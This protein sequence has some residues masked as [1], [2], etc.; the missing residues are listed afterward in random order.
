MFDNHERPH[1]ALGL[2][3]PARPGGTGRA[4]APSPERLEPFDYGPG[5][6]AVVRKVQDKGVIGFENRCWRVKALV[7]PA[8][9]VRPTSSDGVHEVFF[10]H[11][12][13]ATIDRNHAP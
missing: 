7:G 1:Q 6:G 3:V 10:C 9:A 11:R 12:R 2:D 5:P 8:V 4:R 13:V